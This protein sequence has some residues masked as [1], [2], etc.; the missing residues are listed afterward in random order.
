V[1]KRL[2]AFA[3][4]ATL[5]FLV[6]RFV[7]G[8][9]HA[10]KSAPRRL[11]AQ[12]D[13]R[14]AAR[15]ERA[16]PESGILLQS[17]RRADASE[18]AVAFTAS[19]EVAFAAE[20]EVA[21]PD[22]SRLALPRYRVRAADSRPVAER[23]DVVELRDVTVAFFRVGGTPEAPAELRTGTLAAKT[24]LAVIGRNADGK[25]TIAADREMELAGV[26]L[27]T[28][29][30]AP[31][32][33]LRLEVEHAV[34]RQADDVVTLR[35]R[36]SEPFT[37]T[38]AGD[39]P[40]R[41]TGN[42]LAGSIPSGKERGPLSLR[43][44][45]HP[46][47]TLTETDAETELAAAGPLEYDEE[48]GGDGSLRL[49][50][51]VTVTGLRGGSAAGDSLRAALRRGKSV[52]GRQRALLLWL[53]LAGTPARVALGSGAESA[54]GPTSLVCADLL[55]TPGAGGQPYLY[56][57][58]GEPQLEQRAGEAEP[59]VFRATRRIH[60][61]DVGAHLDPWLVPLGFPAG[62]AGRGFEELI[63]FEGESAIDQPSDEGAVSVRSAGGIR[64]VR[65]RAGGAATL[66]GAGSTTATLPGEPPLAL[67]G[68]DGFWMRERA[69]AGGGRSVRLRLGRDAR[70]G[71]H[72]YELT[73]GDLRLAGSGLADLRREGAIDGT[74]E[75]RSDAADVEATFRGASLRGAARLEAAF[76]AG[77]LRTLEA[78]AGTADLQLTDQAAGGLEASARRV[79]SEGSS[80]ALFG[81]PARLRRAPGAEPETDDAL[82]GGEL[83]AARIDVRPIPAGGVW[84]AAREDAHLAADHGGPA[85]AVHVDL[86]ANAIERL[87]FL[88]APW[89]AAWHGSFLPAGLQG[90]F[91]AHLRS[92]HLHATGWV[93]LESS[94]QAEAADRRSASGDELW[95]RLEA[96]AGRLLGSPAAAD[97]LSASGQR[98]RGEAPTI[99]FAGTSADG[100]LHLVPHVGG[101]T[102]LTLAGGS[103]AA[104]LPGASGS[105]V[106]IRCRGPVHAGP[107]EIA[108]LGPVDVRSLDQAGAET[109]E[110]RITADRLTAKRDREGRITEVVAWGRARLA[111][112]R[113]RVDADTFRLDLATATCSVLDPA[114]ALVV[115]AGREFSG[116]QLDANW[117]TLTLRAW[118]G[119][120][121]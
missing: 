56:T 66:V 81:S 65:S 36:P 77:G 76:D 96:P 61:L 99:T 107:D 89:A 63:A 26:V 79:R 16:R 45:S 75:L 117:E 31:V 92:A 9:P 30:A 48:P 119:E 104:K 7:A 85:S 102:V 70:H 4:L 58:H 42:G 91:A 120:M 6:L 38:L 49:R 86:H 21:L 54:S 72:R 50:D 80:L 106:R 14:R 8:E 113:L 39:R 32:K 59:T 40:L 25:P 3:L 10:A 55:V 37:L 97:L 100:L 121:R 1:I 68:S 20:E 111:S 51:A 43:V 53:R 29:D 13:D 52:A 23:D 93:A 44:A 112:D 74:I 82:G 78:H 90:H 115:M 116:T 71:A 46:R 28:T 108:C 35:T 33:G 11:P 73:R 60:M 105:S 83:C 57:A 103:P 110:A 84:L 24:A 114:G 95:L 62:A 94:G 12:P 41:M 27:E 5:G 69:A 101:E 118:Y 47:V 88:A 18:S 109:G 19:G 98:S 15:D 2:L 17:E 22:G 67:A 87:P 34:V 64:A